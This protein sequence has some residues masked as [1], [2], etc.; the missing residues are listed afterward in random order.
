MTEEHTDAS[1]DK[2]EGRGVKQHDANISSVSEMRGG[3]TDNEIAGRGQEEGRVQQ[4]A[5]L[6][7]T[8][9]HP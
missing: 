6:H 8:Y 9:M 1:K 7:H 5:R 2:R 3:K 4:N